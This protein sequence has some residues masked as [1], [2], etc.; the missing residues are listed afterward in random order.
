MF[1]VLC[2]VGKLCANP[3]LIQ[4]VWLGFFFAHLRNSFWHSW[5]FAA[6]KFDKLFAGLKCIVIGQPTPKH[7]LN[8]SNLKKLFH[9]SRI[10]PGQLGQVL[11]VQGVW[12]FT[13]WNPLTLQVVS[14]YC[15]SQ[16][17]KCVFLFKK[18]NSSYNRDI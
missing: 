17:Q 18:Y 8:S 7:L 15:C 16:L 5:P 13:N 1:L 12:F 4:C 14:V 9:C 11:S 2:V 3:S 6:W 10:T